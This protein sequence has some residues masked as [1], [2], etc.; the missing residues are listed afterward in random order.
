MVISVVST[1]LALVVVA[2][3]PSWEVSPLT[4][5][6]NQKSWPALEIPYTPPFRMAGW[7]WPQTVQKPSSPKLWSSRVPIVS[8]SLE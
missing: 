8:G 6:A 2:V 3:M 5:A 4:S 7:Y 1:A